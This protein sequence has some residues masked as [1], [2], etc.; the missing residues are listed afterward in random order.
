V[1]LFPFWL[2]NIAPAFLGVSTRVYVLATFFGIIPGTFVYS[3]VGDGLGVVFDRG[4]TP[5][6]GIIFEP[7][8]L[9]SIIGLAV[10]AMIPVLYKKLRGR[11]RM[12]G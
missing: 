10:L 2:V 8:I 5:D 7:T 11:D 4:E 1:P 3:T 6:L 12:P 9:G